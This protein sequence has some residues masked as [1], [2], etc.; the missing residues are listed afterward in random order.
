M[1]YIDT[2]NITWTFFAPGRPGNRGVETQEP[3]S[4]E[5]W[6]LKVPS[7]GNTPGAKLLSLA[8]P[9]R[10]VSERPTR[11]AINVSRPGG[12]SGAQASRFLGR[13]ESYAY[14]KAR[15]GVAAGHPVVRLGHRP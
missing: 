7:R 13:A 4:L 1:K 15:R 10:R 5:G 14:R 2:A 9:D 3:S 12:R 6:T 8:D 11:Q